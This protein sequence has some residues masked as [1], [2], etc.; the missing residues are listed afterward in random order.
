[1]TVGDSPSALLVFSTLVNYGMVKI[2]CSSSEMVL[3][4]MEHTM[5]YPSSDPSLKVMALHP[6]V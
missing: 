5:T 4:T 3:R 1:V 6:V 2:T